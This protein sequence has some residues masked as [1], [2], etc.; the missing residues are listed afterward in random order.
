MP[1]GCASDRPRFIGCASSSVDGPY[2]DAV[3][4]STYLATT[5]TS[6]LT[7]SP[8][9]RTPSVVCAKVVG[10]NATVKASGA[11]STTVSET[12]STAIEPFSTT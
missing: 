5:S 9:A 6:R 3:S 10:I 8:G 7:V 11:T 2:R 12:P 4:R 1:S